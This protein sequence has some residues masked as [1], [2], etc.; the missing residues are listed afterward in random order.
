MGAGGGGGGGRS[1]LP[2]V[3]VALLAALSLYLGSLVSNLEPPPEAAKSPAS[4][5][6]VKTRSDA[7]GAS[8]AVVFEAKG[9]VIPV[10]QI[11]VSPKVGGMVEKL[12]VE[13]G[14]RV[15]KGDILCELE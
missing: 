6:A 8:G 5:P 12:Y 3:L 9:Y 14:K 11:Q 15:K 7:R 2:W 1:W 4:R 10:Q 13:E